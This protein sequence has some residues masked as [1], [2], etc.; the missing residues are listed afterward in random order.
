MDNESDGTFTA[1]EFTCLVDHRGHVTLQIGLHLSPGRLHFIC[2][3]DERAELACARLAL[4]SRLPGV[5]IMMDDPIRRKCLRARSRSCNIPL[6]PQSRHTQPA[7]ASVSCAPSPAVVSSNTSIAAPAAAA[8]PTVA[9]PSAPGEAQL[10]PGDAA[11]PA[12]AAQPQPPAPA[13]ALEEE[14]DGL[15]E[16]EREQLR[17][18]IQMSMQQD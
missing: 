17:Q 10:P 5:V 9:R 3:C 8:P 11:S 1:V 12:T 18:A 14:D 2:R 4:V 13:A 16:D 15:D 6:E 7:V